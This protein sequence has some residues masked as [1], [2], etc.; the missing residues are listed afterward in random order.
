MAITLSDASREAIDSLLPALRRDLDRINAEIQRLRLRGEKQIAEREAKLKSARKLLQ[1][2]VK[3]KAAGFSMRHMQGVLL[4]ITQ[5]HSTRQ[6]GQTLGISKTQVKR[7]VRG[8]FQNTGAKTRAEL[9]AKS[10][11]P[12]GL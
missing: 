8:L 1:G 9:V 11:R 6:I 5:G 7:V 2:P 10:K 4:G 12:V 3:R